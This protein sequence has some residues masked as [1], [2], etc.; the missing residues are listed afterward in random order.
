M[1]TKE[2][3]EKI[4]ERYL[5][6][7]KEALAEKGEEI[8][9]TASNKI[10]IPTVE[11][12]EEAYITLTFAVPTG[13]HDGEAYDGYAEAENYEKELEKKK[14]KAEASAKKKSAK[15]AKDKA[16]REAKAKAKAES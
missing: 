3:R 7:V 13:S 12:G 15:I 6:L 2:Q 9:V 5:A 11:D 1:A 8:L 10:A 14:A 4:R 16:D